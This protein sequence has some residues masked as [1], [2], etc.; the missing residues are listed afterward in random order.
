MLPKLATIILPLAVNRL[1]YILFSA[2]GGDLAS[3][4]K[5]IRLSYTPY[6]TRARGPIYVQYSDFPVAEPIIS[7]IRRRDDPFV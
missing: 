3:R 5:L 4:C 7:Y 6:M 1:T 2:Y